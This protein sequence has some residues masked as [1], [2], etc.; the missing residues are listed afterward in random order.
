MIDCNLQTN[1]RNDFIGILALDTSLKDLL[2]V[3]II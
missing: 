2:R 3:L 1:L